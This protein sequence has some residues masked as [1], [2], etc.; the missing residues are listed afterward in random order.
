M[1]KLTRRRTFFFCNKRI[2]NYKLDAYKTRSI[3][4][5]LHFA[6]DCLSR[7]LESESRGAVQSWLWVGGVAIAEARCPCIISR[8]IIVCWT[9]IQR[10]AERSA[11]SRQIL[12][13]ILFADL[14]LWSLR[15]HRWS[16]AAS[17]GHRSKCSPTADPLPR[18]L[19]VTFYEPSTIMI[20]D[21]HSF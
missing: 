1:K 20:R 16:L 6:T 21:T 9:C 13:I 7:T 19:T 14:L 11:L 8:S 5:L 15:G 3:D 12:H 18:P 2:N 10:A 4:S 17:C